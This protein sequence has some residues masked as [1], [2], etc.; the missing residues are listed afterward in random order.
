MEGHPSNQMAFKTVLTNEGGA[1]NADTGVFTC[2]VSGYYYFNAAL[3]KHY[4]HDG[5]AYC[6]IYKNGGTLVVATTRPEPSPR[7]GR[8]AAVNGVYTR[9]AV[10]DAVTLGSCNTPIATAFHKY[11]SFSGFLV[12]PDD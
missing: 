8:Y 9:L 1:F 10:N 7:T 3:L 5:T 4:N 6:I 2:P 11:S 12:T